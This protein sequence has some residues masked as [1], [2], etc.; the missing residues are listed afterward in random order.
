LVR[1]HSRILPARR[2]DIDTESID[3]EKLK[4]VLGKM[5]AADIAS[6]TCE[7][8]RLHGGTLGDVRLA[9]GAALTAGGEELPYKAVWKTQKKWERYGDP[10]SWRRE[11]D[12]YMS[13]LGGAFSD[14]LRWPECYHA[15]LA[16]S[17]T[18]IWMEHIDG[19]SGLDLSS[20]MYELA[21]KELG[22]F[23]G[24]LQTRRAALAQS[25]A[26]LS[27]AAFM[28]NCYLH[29][30]SWSEVY[31]YIR[32]A[33]CELP[34]HLC[35]MLIDIDDGEAEIFARIGKLPIILCHRDFWVANIF[36]S[37][38]KIVLIDWDT[39]GWGHMGE[40]VASLIADEADPARM[41]ELY[42]R[43]VPAYYGGFSE[44]ADVS[45]VRDSCMYE[46]ILLMFGY[47]LVEWFKRAGTP[48]EKT[49]HLDTLQQIY[50]MR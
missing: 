7:T 3:R 28:R 34:R 25:L 44:Y 24:R 33:K 29:Y 45:H 12:L 17:E 20:D 4:I 41:A 8:R 26:N 42:S 1:R 22:R 30:R 40:D 48:E 27:G 47:R 32:D 18:Q 19:V 13:D 50:E 39:A 16:D 6:A 2:F 46:L 11:Y 38:G 10:G 43:C 23:Q 21:A 14:A 37:G 15:E 9:E 35:K 49:L 31:D 5:F 36:C